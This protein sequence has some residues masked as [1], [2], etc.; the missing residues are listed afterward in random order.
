MS[1]EVDP[2]L[3]DL[4]KAIIDKI[5]RTAEA[6]RQKRI[7]ASI[8]ESAREISRVIAHY[9][10]EFYGRLGLVSHIEHHLGLATERVLSKVGEKIDQACALAFRN[11]QAKAE[12]ELASLI[13]A[14]QL[15]DS[16]NTWQWES[17]VVRTEFSQIVSIYKGQFRQRDDF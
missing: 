9:G 1:G 5:V 16:A 17:D 4:R 8:R 2:K 10:D 12:R 15:R 14:E 7:D 6:D 3:E 11:E 13:E